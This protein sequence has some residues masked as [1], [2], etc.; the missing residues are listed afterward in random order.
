MALNP[1][2]NQYTGHAFSTKACFMVAGDRTTSVNKGKRAGPMSDL[3]IWMSMGWRMVR[4]IGSTGLP[5]AG[6][7][8]LPLNPVRAHWIFYLGQPRHI[9]P[10]SQFN[11]LFKIQAEASYHLLNH[12][13]EKEWMVCSGFEPRAAE[14]KVQ[15]HPLNQFGLPLNLETSYKR[16]NSF[17][18]VE[19][20]YLGRAWEQFID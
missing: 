17:T 6:P 9:F 16:K 7:F 20:T 1:G 12:I 19:L 15:M 13:L 5:L 3:H 8:S 18:W 11:D 4:V 10:F 14:L 2:A